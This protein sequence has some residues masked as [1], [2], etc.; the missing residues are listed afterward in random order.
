VAQSIAATLRGVVT[1]SLISLNVI[2]L[3]PILMV[4]AL[5][6]LIVPLAPWR[7]YMGRVMIVIA[8]LWI[9]NNTLVLKGLARLRI[10]ARG[11]E[12]LQRRDWYLV[13]SNHRS[14]VDILVLQAVFRGR[15]PFL[16]FFLKQQLIWVP[17]LGLAWWA[18]DFPF[19]RRHSSEYLAKHPEERGKDLA[20]TRKACRKFAEIPTSV[21]N[22][23][24]GTRYTAAKREKFKSPYRHLLPPRAGG[25]AFVLSAMGGTLHSMVDVTL[26]YH[27]AGP[28][29]WQL[30]C[31]RLQPVVVEVERRPIEPWT[32]EG[33]YQDDEAF[34][35]RF[36]QW[37]GE[38]WQR[39]DAR[40]ATL[41]AGESG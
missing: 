30:C 3:V 40:L 32:T 24:E 17:L 38:L 39:K 37:L 7:R 2:V 34:R 33:N 6:R 21:M 10:D 28:T 16:K 26:A 9:A 8:E 14:W 20:E 4:A 41:L 29:L 5:L 15:I 12:G 13:V 25:V 22:F 19:M 31:G 36:Q 18:L 11:L 27:E 35:R 1:I 23:V